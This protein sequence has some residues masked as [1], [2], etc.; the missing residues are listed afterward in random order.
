[1]VLD[2]PLKG[3]VLMMEKL[4]YKEI[5]KRMKSVLGRAPFDATLHLRPPM[6]P[7]DDFIEM[8][9]ALSPWGFC[10]SFPSPDPALEGSHGSLCVICD[11]DPPLP[12]DVARTTWNRAHARKGSRGRM[13]GSG[14]R[15]I[16]LGG[17]RSAR[18]IRGCSERPEKRRRRR[19][20]AMKR[21]MR[22]MMIR[23]STH[24]IGWTPWPKRG[25][26]LRGR[27]SRSRGGHRRLSCSS[28]R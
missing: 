18:S 15:P 13:I 25:N 5:K 9:S 8:V 19:S 20:Q 28:A 24:T 2:A 17:R 4:D 27:P 1:V 14:R 7:N 16:G 6:C 10:T 21:T 12:E 23:G 3:M 26:S 11:F 22:M